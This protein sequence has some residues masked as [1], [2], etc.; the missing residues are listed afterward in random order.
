MSS[1]LGNW[2]SVS[3]HSVGRRENLAISPMRRGHDADT[4]AAVS[5]SSFH[6]LVSVSGRH[7]SSAE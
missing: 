7:A 4:G 6:Q 5:A 1:R 3:E 2:G